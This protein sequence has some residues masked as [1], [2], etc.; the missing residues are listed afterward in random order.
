MLTLLKLPSKFKEV[1][2]MK[3]EILEASLLILADGKSHQIQQKLKAVLSDVY[4]LGVEYG[5]MNPFCG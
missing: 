4:E 3:D 2:Y 5:A 1:P